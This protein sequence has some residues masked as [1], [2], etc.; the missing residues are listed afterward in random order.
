M[1]SFNN[2]YS[3]GA[4]PQILQALQESNDIQTAGYGM[5]PYCEEAIALIRQKAETD[6]EVFFVSGGTQCN[7][8]LIGHALRPY[9]AVIS[10]QTGHINTHEAGAVEATGHKILPIY[11]EN[12][13]ITAAQIKDLMKEFPA[14]DEHLVRPAMV[15]ISHPTELGTLYKKKELE[16]LRKVCDEHQMLL[17]LD[18]AR[19]ASALTAKGNDVTLA[20]L[21]K[22]CDAF[23]LGGT[24][25]GALLGEALLVPNKACAKNMRW[26]MKRHGAILAKGRL[27]GIQFAELFRNDLYT[28]L[29]KH[30]NEMAEILRAGISSLG[31]EFLAKD[32]S[33][34]MFPVL[35]NRIIDALR[36]DY[37]FATWKAGEEE[38]T[39]R[40]VTSWHTKQE[41]VHDFITALS[42][43]TL[44]AC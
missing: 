3:E 39:I 25:C 43:L 18:G 40:L 1:I 2:D 42:K 4:H 31:Y 23:Y 17:Y 12:G 21:A 16:A 34:Q 27:L 35:P 22:L 36:K 37:V 24:K 38:S 9:E 15:Y 8:L 28:E 20:D 6:A 41:D 5:D 10:A 14:D 44:A 11:S 19:M 30:A 33:N 13:K 32:N 26:S 7:Q 29:G